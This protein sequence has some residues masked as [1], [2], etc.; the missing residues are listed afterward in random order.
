MEHDSRES[1]SGFGAQPAAILAAFIIATT[2]LL[3][4]G[5]AYRLIGSQVVL[6][7]NDLTNVVVALVSTWLASLLWRTFRRGETL[8]IVWGYLTV[9]LV[10]WTAG[11]VIWSSDQLLFGNELPYPSTADVLWIGGYIPVILALAVRFFTFRIPLTR[12]WQYVILGSFLVGVVFAIKYVIIPSLTENLWA[13]PLEILVT[14]LYPIGDLIVA[15]F[16]LLLVLVL[17]GGLLFGPWRLIAVGYFCFAASDLFYA[18]A[19]LD[20]VYQVDPA[21]GLNLIS[22]SINLLYTAAYVLVALGL[23]QRARLEHIL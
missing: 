15:L 5:P 9:G 22:Y 4:I 20:Q 16:A 10:M 6:W 1:V 11:E 7:I 17:S 21:S 2:A 12:L 3:Y 14:T 8:S 13:G 19:I 18:L 23:Y